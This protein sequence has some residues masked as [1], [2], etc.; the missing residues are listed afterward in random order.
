M[1]EDLKKNNII[2]KYFKKGT[3][4]IYL[5]VSTPDMPCRSLVQ[6]GSPIFLLG[7]SHGFAVAY[8]G[9]K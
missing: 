5:K 3:S 8:C 7:V 6:I 1:R 4:K 9:T 2:K